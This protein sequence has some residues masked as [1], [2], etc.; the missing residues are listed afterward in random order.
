[1]LTFDEKK[2]VATATIQKQLTESDIENIM[3][4]AIEGGIGYWAILCNEKTRP[5]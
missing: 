4:T 5:E 1:V 2:V 3:V